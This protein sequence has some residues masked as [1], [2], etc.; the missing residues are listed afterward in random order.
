MDKISKIF[1]NILFWELLFL[2]IFIPLYPK[3]PLLNIS[4]TFVAV[5]LEDLFIFTEWFNVVNI[6]FSFSAV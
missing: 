5:R 2:A 3:F 1:R 4:N 6:Y